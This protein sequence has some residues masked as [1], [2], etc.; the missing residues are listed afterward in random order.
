MIW[1]GL[2]VLA[3]TAAV[4]VLGVIGLARLTI[5]DEPTFAESIDEVAEAGGDIS[6]FLPTALG[7]ELVISGAADGATIMDR[8]VSGPTYGIG[9]SQS[10]MFFETDPLVITQMSHEGLAFFPEPDDCELTV[11]EINEEMGLAA[12]QISCPELVDIRDNGSISVEG[13]VALP[14]DL[15]VDL[16]LPETGGTVTVGDVTYDPVEPFLFIGPTHEGSGVEETGLRLVDD[17]VS[18]EVYVFFSYDL[19]S[20]SLAISEVYYRSGIAE[21]GP[22]EC[23]SRTEELMAINPQAS[24]WE[25]TFSCESVDVSSHGA[26]AVEGEVIFQKVFVTEDH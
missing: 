7:G 19:P 22:D 12:V 24:V 15:V 11:G 21:I 10:R 26:L 4:I 13:L 18:P 23:R 17:Q 25:V 2:G 20:D 1:K 5:P 8:Q 3:G 16:D 6:G 14:A 9:N